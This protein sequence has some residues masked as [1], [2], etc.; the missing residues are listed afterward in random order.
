MK[1]RILCAILIA[2]VAFVYFVA[3]ETKAD[4]LSLG[5]FSYHLGKHDEPLNSYH[6]IRGIEINNVHV[7]QL[8]NS[9]Y[10]EV[11]AVGYEFHLAKNETVSLSVMPALTYGYRDCSGSN[12]GT[13]KKYC[14]TLVPIIRWHNFEIAEP[15]V[16]IFG[17]AIVFY[18]TFPLDF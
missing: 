12:D 14:P 1:H 11:S 7:I 15:S 5:G 3:P 10:Q 6:E 9:H 8:L 18:L 13:D 4:S 16:A 17:S 2:L